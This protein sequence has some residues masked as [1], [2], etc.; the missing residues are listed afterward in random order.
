MHAE[1]VAI[2]PAGAVTVAMQH[3]LSHPMTSS[4][5]NSPYPIETNSAATLACRQGRTAFGIL[6]QAI[7]FLPMYVYLLTQSVP[8]K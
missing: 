6:T 8:Q 2:C 7:N 3:E 5:M 4:F 1:N